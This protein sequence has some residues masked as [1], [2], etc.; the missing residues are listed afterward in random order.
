MGGRAVPSPHVPLGWGT[1]GCV[2]LY[3]DILPL[4]Y[5]GPE[6][7][8]A[9]STAWGG[10][11]SGGRP[12]STPSAE[13]CLG[14][15]GDTSRGSRVWG[16]A[17]GVPLGVAAPRCVP[18]PPTAVRNDRNKKKKEVKE[19]AADSPELS[20]ALEELIQKVSRAHQETFPSLCQL[21]KYTMVSCGGTVRLSVTPWGHQSPHGTVNH[22]LGLSVTVWGHQSPHG[23]IGHPVGLLIIPWDRWSPHGPIG[24]PVGLS[25]TLWG[26]WSP[27][28]TAGHPVGLAVTPW[29]HQSPCGAVDHPMGPLVPPWTHRSPCGAVSHP[30]GLLVT[31][32]GC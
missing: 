3:V 8:G 27:H 15:G 9:G 13:Q 32:W 1:R 30:V 25:V 22:P 7:R 23:A 28:G 12:W 19:E 14:D 31:L 26:Y 11:G 10:D 24:H 29:G 20:P 21:G 5:P 4:P 6:P 2:V 16:D 17:C 18:L